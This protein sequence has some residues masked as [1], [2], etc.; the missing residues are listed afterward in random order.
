MANFIFNSAAAALTAAALNLSTG[1]YYAHLVTTTPLLTDT[2]VADLILP[3][4]PG[5]IGTPLTGLVYTAS[6]WTFNSFSFPKF[7][8]ATSAPKGVVICR[9]LGTTPASTD[10][11]ICYS[12]FTN[13]ID[14]AITLQVGTYAVNLQFGP[15]GAINFNYRYQYNSGSYSTIETI[16]KGLIYLI[17]SQNNTFGNF[18]QIPST[19]V[20]ASLLVGTNNFF[21]ANTSFTDRNTG[22]STATT[23]TNM[24][25]DFI[26]NRVQVG[27]LGFRATFAVTNQV[28]I[29]GSND[30]LVIN[31]TSI[32]SNVGW[33]QLGA[34]ASLIV[35]W[36]LF[37]IN[38]PTYWRFIK[39]Q[40]LSLP[41]SE[42]EF[43]DSAILSPTINLV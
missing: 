35:G 16:P 22:T 28:T 13:S 18:T 19:K 24:V 30:N 29:F 3:N 10:Q 7:I 27:K 33:T 6:L 1:N 31:S 25:L 43:Y 42:V 8:F 38:S 11:L 4:S 20:N 37:D 12:D 32:S 2:T 41:C 26:N 40:G 9:R 23:T 14:Q 15:N 17:G 34:L 5:Y 39:I 21:T 36:N